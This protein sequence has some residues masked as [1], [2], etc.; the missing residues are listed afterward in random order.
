MAQRARLLRLAPLYLS[1]AGALLLTSPAASAATVRQG[2]GFNGSVSGF[3]IGAV[4]LTGGGAYD[5]NVAD[6]V[7][8]G[9]ANS[10][11]GFSCTARVDQGPLSGNP[12]GSDPCLAGEGVRWDTAQLLRDTMFK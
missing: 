11:G 1:L 4:T 10:S 6:N 7:A 9:F 2:F 5:P 8:G 3:P 12:A